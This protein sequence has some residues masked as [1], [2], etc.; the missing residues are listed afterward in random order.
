[1]PA[2]IGIIDTLIGFAHPDVKE[3]YRWVTRQTRDPVELESPVEFLFK[4]VPDKRMT[5]VKDRVGATLD[6]MDR[7]GVER[8]MVGVAEP[9]DDGDAALRRYPD[10]F[11]PS[12]GCDPNDARGGLATLVR[13][14]ETWGVRAVTLFPAGALPAV[15]INDPRMYPVYSTCV[16]LGLPVFCTAGVP[17]PRLRLTAQRVE[18]I[19]E[20]MYDFPGLVFV[21]R[22]GADPWAE[23]AVKLMLKW[24]GLH[25]STSGFAPRYYPRAIIDFANTRGADQIVYAGYFPF[26]LTLE[27]IMKEMAHLPLRDHVWPRFLRANALRVLGLSS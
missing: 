13:A 2:G 8:G 7:W 23:L 5:G 25:Y 14:Y 10:R 17:G 20:V 18:L 6:E 11:I 21:I 16:E 9:G 3:A 27:R 1:M 12:T 24:P 22:H 19:D 4:D 26:G 15:P